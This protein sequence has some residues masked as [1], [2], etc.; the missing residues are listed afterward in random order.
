MARNAVGPS[1][2]MVTGT[3]QMLG[4]NVAGF[5]PFAFSCTLGECGGW[6]DCLFSVAYER[7]N[8]K[9]FNG[10]GKGQTTYGVQ[11]ESHW[12]MKKGDVAWAVARTVKSSP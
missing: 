9:A 2:Y 11:Y 7:L 3:A 12:Q 4:G 10:A 8:M 6:R 1:A 5:S